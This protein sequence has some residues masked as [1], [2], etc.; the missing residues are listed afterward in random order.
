MCTQR[1]GHVERKEVICK[2][3]RGPWDSSS[4]YGPQ[5]KPTPWL[6]DLGLLAS[7]TVRKQTS[8]V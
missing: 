3:R 6:L 2:S 5:R 7:E 1:G 8:V 4:S